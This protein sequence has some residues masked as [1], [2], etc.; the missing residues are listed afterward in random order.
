VK[1]QIA[2][3]LVLLLSGAA[4]VQAHTSLPAYLELKETTPGSFAM[5]WRVPA[6][7]G[8]P[9]AIYPVF[10]SNCTVPRL[11]AEDAPGSVVERGT[12]QCEPK[13]LAEQ[14]LAIEGLSVTIL[15]VLVRITFTDG[16]SVTQILRP[17]EPS[18]IVHKG[19]RS[20]VDALGYVRLGIGHILYGID[21]LLFVLG[22]LLIVPGV[23]TLLKTIT[24]F[25]LAH[26]TTLA[27]A[28]LGVVRVSPTPIEAVI[29]LSIVFLAAELAQHRRG[30]QGLTY[31]KPWIV[32]FAFGLLHG[33]G[34]AGTLSRIGIPP[35]DI[36]LA[37]F[38]FNLGVE[39]GQ[40]A[41]VAAVLA[42]IYSLRTLDIQWP[43][44][45]YNVPPYAIG[46]L[47]SLWFL[48]RC[49]LTFSF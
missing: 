45:T 24:A 22:L 31:R 37:L 10:P 23:R 12:I 18:F 39:A 5:L 4:N 36:P 2:V 44:W 21:H 16:T 40:V 3:S 25:T 48:Q 35:R 27:L 29:A 19:G 20:R 11:I 34:F 8:P 14:K 47:A 49:A 15:D 7:E 17:L 41:F 30:I 13:G 33:F 9:P 1:S 32:A 43:Q 38:S 42:F 6:A 26:T 28:T 46:S